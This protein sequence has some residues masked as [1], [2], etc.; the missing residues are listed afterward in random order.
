MPIDKPTYEF[1][2]FPSDPTMGVIYRKIPIDRP[3]LGKAHKR[4]W[5]ALLA[6]PKEQKPEEKDRLLL[7]LEA[8]LRHATAGLHAELAAEGET[9]PLPETEPEPPLAE[10]LH[11]LCQHCGW[12]GL[13]TEGRNFAREQGGPRKA[14]CPVCGEQGSLIDAPKEKQQP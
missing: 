7:R 8:M 6:F 10:C 4:Q 11:A 3:D 14:R 2:K 12:H 5:V 13:W 1:E 9:I